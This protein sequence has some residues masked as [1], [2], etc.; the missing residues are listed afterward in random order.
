VSLRLAVLL[1][2]ARQAPELKALTLQ[3]EGRKLRL[4]PEPAWAQ[5]HPRTLYLLQQEREAW[6]RVGALVL[7]VPL[8]L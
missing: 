7:E 1:C 6:E 2:H 4:V 3:R 8:P 5:R